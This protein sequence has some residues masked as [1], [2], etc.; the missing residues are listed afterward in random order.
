M[1]VSR[2][3][4]IAGILATSIAPAALGRAL[5][6]SLSRPHRVLEPDWEAVT[7]WLE[8]KIAEDWEAMLDREAEKLLHGTG[9]PANEPRGIMSFK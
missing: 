8:Q 4:M 2:R 6:D 3:A 7:R 9:D 5:V 1:N